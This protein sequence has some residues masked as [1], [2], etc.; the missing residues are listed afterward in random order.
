MDLL[1]NTLKHLS[2][3]SGAK[4]KKKDSRTREK[5][6]LLFIFSTNYKLLAPFMAKRTAR[7]LWNYRT[8]QTR[9]CL[10]KKDTGK[11][12]LSAPCGGQ[13][14]QGKHECKADQFR[15]QRKRLMFPGFTRSCNVWAL[16][17]HRFGASDG[18]IQIQLETWDNNNECPSPVSLL[19]LV[20]FCSVTPRF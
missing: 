16:I 7:C 3:N 12:K 19:I 6:V 17:K 5:V 15:L 13:C 18:F 14:E 4:K 8:R 10:R 11:Y 1:A 20:T 2:L 9:V